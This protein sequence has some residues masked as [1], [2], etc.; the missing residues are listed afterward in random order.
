MLEGLPNELGAELL[1]NVWQGFNVSIFAYGQT[2]SG[3]TYTTPR[4]AR[5]SENA[6]ATPTTSAREFEDAASAR[7]SAR[8]M[9]D[10]LDG[11]SKDRC[12]LL[13]VDCRVAES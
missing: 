7:G 9:D 6:Y 10:F 4:S 13:F 1:A 3:K 8:E 12:L 5:S 2:G 11:S